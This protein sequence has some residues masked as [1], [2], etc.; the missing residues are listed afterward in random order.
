MS[1]DLNDKYRNYKKMTN[2]LIKEILKNILSLLLFNVSRLFP[3]DKNLWVFGTGKN[4][5]ES[6]RYLYEYIKRK[7][8]EIRCVWIVKKKEHLEY[9]KKIA[10]EAYYHRT[11]KAIKYMLRAR[12]FLTSYGTDGFGVFH[13]H[14][15]AIM[16]RLFHYIPIKAPNR[17]LKMKLYKF[18]NFLE[19][20][21]GERAD[22]A[23]ASSEYDKRFIEC[24]Y[25]DLVKE[26]VITGKPK[27]DIFFEKID[28]DKLIK[29]WIGSDITF[30]KVICYLPSHRINKEKSDIEIN[31]HL[32]DDWNEDE[33]E[34]FLEENNAILIIKKHPSYH[35]ENESLKKGKRI[36][37][38]PTI[39]NTQ[40]ILRASDIL[41]TDY[42]T[43][44]VDYLLLDRPIIFTPFDLDHFKRVR[45]FFFDYERMAPGPKVTT[46][47]SII[48]EIDTYI[49]NPEK[50]GELRR[51]IR[52]IFY[53]YIDNKS[54]ERVTAEILK[55]L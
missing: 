11:V 28:R 29:K 48:K 24:Q 46:F 38:L 27:S 10:D 12:V 6:Q 34:K 37:H 55:R 39:T 23:V 7:H 9:T 53:K 32:R 26:I 5:N 54:C 22:I 14:G 41:I 42:S 3:R 52:R 15:G 44:F 8:P 4:P 25:G 1:H 18:R 2:R 30:S 45:G 16:V 51:S 13:L 36:I 47:K 31:M 21:S 20:L 43:V 50:D 17:N 40:D 19:I 49:K 33:M 35:K